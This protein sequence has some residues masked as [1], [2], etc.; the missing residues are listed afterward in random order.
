[1]SAVNSAATRCMSA[2]IFIDT[3]VF[4]Y[5][6]EAL[7][8]RKFQIAERI[9]RQAVATGN[10]CISFQVV[11]ECL[12]TILRKAEIPLDPSAARDY[13]E[14]VLFP[15]FQVQASQAL[16]GRALD[17]YGR[18][19]FSFYDALIIAAALG[20]GC[21]KLYSEDLQDG[22]RIERLVIENPFRED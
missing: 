18:Y 15:L 1:M 8:E 12:N 11:Q 21:T 10:A 3:N 9:I 14:T 6:L 16:Y 7:D 22:Q 17:L 13:L 5:H 19:K 2:K 4:I 20:E